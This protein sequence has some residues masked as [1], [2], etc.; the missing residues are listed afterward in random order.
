MQLAPGRIVHVTHADLDGCRPAIVVRAFSN[1]SFNGHIFLDGVNDQAVDHLA[2]E[3]GSHSWI[4][5]VPHDNGP[6][7]SDLS[8]HSHEE[9]PSP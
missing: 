5:S 3:P 6:F 9:C 7:A 2:A 8:W 4:T 1:G